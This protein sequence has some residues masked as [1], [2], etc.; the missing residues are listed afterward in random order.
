[1]LIFWKQTAISVFAMKKL[2]VAGIIDRREIK[3]QASLAQ[4]VLILMA[5]QW[6][7]FQLG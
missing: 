5:S 3:E 1:M 6:C 2:F 4:L 7:H